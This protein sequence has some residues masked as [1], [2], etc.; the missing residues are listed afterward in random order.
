MSLL[1]RL[2]RSEQAG[3]LLII[4]VMVAGLSL[5][6]G[7]HVD[8]ATGRTVNNFFNSYTLI[9]TATDASFFAIMAVGATI[10]IISGGIDLSVGS[11]YALAGVTM[12]LMLRAHPGLGGGAAV[13]LSLLGLRR[14]R[15]WRRGRERP[16]GRRAAR[17]PV[18]HHARQHVDPAR[19]R[20]RDQQGREHPLARAADA[21]SR[22]RRWAWAPRFTPSRCWRWCWSPPSAPSIWG[23][24]SWGG[25]ST[26]SAGIRKPAALPGCVWAASR[27]ASTCWPV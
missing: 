6:A 25:T 21:R 24:P 8:D 18:H 13:M 1:R 26:R 4:A 14:R 16:P 9:Q 20:V 19:D 10:V 27:W 2:L 23:A 22:R 3:L 11:V 17:A 7:S 15:P 12:G 5:A